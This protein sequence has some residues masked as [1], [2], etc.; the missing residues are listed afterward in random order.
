[1]LV[2]SRKQQEFVQIGDD[3]VVKVIRTSRGAVKIGIEAPGG[4]RVLRGELAEGDLEDHPP[5]RMSGRVPGAM[6][7]PGGIRQ[8]EPASYEAHAP[9]SVPRTGERLRHTEVL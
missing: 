9:S 8:G 6:K 2:I 7:L 3:I 4:V 5:R 1:M